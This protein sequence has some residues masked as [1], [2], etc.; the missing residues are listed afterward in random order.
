MASETESVR[1]LHDYV[2]LKSAVP[3]GLDDFV[4]LVVPE[5]QRRW[6]VPARNTKALTLLRRI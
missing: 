2:S 3:G 6:P 1:W 4:N 5:L